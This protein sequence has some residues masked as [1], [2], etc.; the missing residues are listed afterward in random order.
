MDTTHKRIGLLW[1]PS[2]KAALLNHSPPVW[3]PTRLDHLRRSSYRL[4]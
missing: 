3:A 4:L 1:C 2:S